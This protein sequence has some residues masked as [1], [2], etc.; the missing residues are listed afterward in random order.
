VD[1]SASC[2]PLSLVLSLLMPLS[3]SL[4]LSLLMPLSLSLVLSLLILL[5]LSL[6]LSLLPNSIIAVVSFVIAAYTHSR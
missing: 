2:Y 6:V 1:Y 3:L 5:S 4:V